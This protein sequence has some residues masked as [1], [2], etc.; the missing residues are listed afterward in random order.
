MNKQ[1]KI[2][3]A[4]CCALLAGASV[5]QSKGKTTS[6]TTSTTAPWMSTEVGDAWSQGYKGQGV[7]ITV[8]DDFSSSNRF[9]GKLDSKS[10]TLRHGEWTLKEASMIA[11]SSTMR[12]HEFNSGTAVKLHQGMNV[13]NL[14]YG[15]FGKAG[16][17][18][19]QIGW[20]A[21]EKSIIQ[22]ATDGAAIVSKAAGNDAIAVGG[23]NAAGNVDYLNLAIKGTPSALY[24]GALSTN[25][26][27][28]S[29]A[30]LAS[31]SNYAGADTTVQ[32]Q[33][34]VVG[35]EGSKTN[36][37]GTSFAAP[38]VSGYGAI[39][40]SK[41]TTATPTQIKNQLLSTARKDTIANYNAAV[42]GQGEASLTRA[43]APVSIY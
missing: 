3:A 10:Q 7:T 12:S 21:Q 28:S 8:V 16:Y 27:V 17:S 29:P 36:L 42:H 19:S 34:L 1:I 37:Y 25:G 26:T 15:M 22:Y 32:S 39:L 24:V 30:K 20:S 18:V 13:L 31:Y 6:T 23:T 5:A 2:A 35:V 11:P 9:S 43:L 40:S 14:S 4:L 41:F 33:F 38:I